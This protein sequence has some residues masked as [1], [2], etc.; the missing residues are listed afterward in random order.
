MKTNLLK[1]QRK[2]PFWFDVFYGHALRIRKAERSVDKSINVL[3]K[4]A[5]EL[6]GW[7]DDREDYDAATVSIFL[8]SKLKDDLHNELN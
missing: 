5:D 4:L 7:E 2:C 6:Y 3:R 8:L 1:L